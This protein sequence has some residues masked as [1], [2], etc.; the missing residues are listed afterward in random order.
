MIVLWLFLAMISVCLQFVIVV[1]PDHTHLKLDT[2]AILCTNILRAGPYGFLSP[3]S[4]VEGMHVVLAI[5]KLRTAWP[6]FFYINLLEEL[7]KIN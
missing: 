1:F 4:K 5:L 7:S 3:V 6:S 2:N